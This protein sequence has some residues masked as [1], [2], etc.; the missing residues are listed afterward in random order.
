MGRKNYQNKAILNVFGTKKVLWVGLLTLFISL[1]YLF[2]TA[3]E[4]SIFDFLGLDSHSLLPFM[5]E[6]LMYCILHAIGATDFENYYSLFYDV[7]MVFSIIETLMLIVFTVGL[8]MLYSAGSN[9]NE[10]V[11]SRGCTAV[12]IF[13]GYHL[14]SVMAQAVLIVAMIVINLVSDGYFDIGMLLV[15][16]IYVLSIIYFA[17]TFAFFG[18]IRKSLNGN[19]SQGEVCVPMFIMVVNWLLFI[20]WIFW[21]IFISG[22]SEA[23]LGMVFLFTTIN[24]MLTTLCYR[25]YEKQRVSGFGEFT[26]SAERSAT[27]DFVNRF[28][29]RTSDAGSLSTSNNGYSN[30]SSD[31]E[32]YEEEDEYEEEQEEEEQVEE[33]TAEEPEIEAVS[34]DGNTVNVSENACAEFAQMLIDL[35]Y[36]GGRFETVMY[37]TYERRNNEAYLYALTLLKEKKGS[38]CV[39]KV[40]A[41][42]G[43]GNII[44][45]MSASIFPCDEKLKSNVAVKDV[46]YDVYSRDAGKIFADNYGV[47][48]PEGTEHC[49]FRLKSVTLNGGYTVIVN[50]DYVL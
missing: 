38:K 47:M 43:N 15:L 31:E 29:N 40:S 27:E 39:L 14:F 19:P 16:V 50:S 3:A 34:D 26:S 5:F 8:F 12:N 35:N 45:G 18:G 4:A 17:K 41:R 23:I 28:A 46:H 6:E 30:N 33:E 42:N 21:T 22:E 36:V 49:V 1:I 37:K 44:C 9:S 48:L 2:A 25:A 7:S 32:E 10:Q 13:L 20:F 11:A 24:T